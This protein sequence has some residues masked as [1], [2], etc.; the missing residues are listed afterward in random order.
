MNNFELSENASKFLKYQSCEKYNYVEIK[1]LKPECPPNVETQNACP[2]K[3]WIKSKLQSYFDD[4]V[5][6]IKPIVERQSQ[7]NVAYQHT[8]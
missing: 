7:G 6:F 3:R 1:R 2:Q 8:W 4:F 5:P